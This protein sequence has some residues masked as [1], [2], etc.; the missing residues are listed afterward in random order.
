MDTELFSVY[1]HEAVHE[2]VV[3]TG[4]TGKRNNPLSS[5]TVSN[6]TEVLTL[7]N[8][9][10]AP[11]TIAPE[12]S[13]SVPSTAPVCDNAGLANTSKKKR[14][15]VPT[16]K[17]NISFSSDQCGLNRALAMAHISA[18]VHERTTAPFTMEFWC[19]RQSK[20]A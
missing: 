13:A 19:S 8:L 17:R 20:T 5:V 10:A 2:L 11:G 1:R 3:P 14:T 6:S 4:T 16:L 12:G 9:T 7:V 15:R 18:A